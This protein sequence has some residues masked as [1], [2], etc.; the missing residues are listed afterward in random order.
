MVPD[1]RHEALD[2]TSPRGT[3]YLV[4]AQTPYTWVP[5]RTMTLT[6]RSAIEATSLSRA[7]R[8]ELRAL[9]RSVPLY[10]VQTMEHAV[11]DATAT[12]RFSTLLRKAGP[13][14]RPELLY[15]KRSDS[16]RR[17]TRC[18]SL[19]RREGEP[20]APQRP[21]TGCPEEPKCCSTLRSR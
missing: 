3:L 20:R 13:G 21:S 18:P 8:R 17:A 4:H 9:D 1:V 7:I 15:V 14:P 11:S 10:Q 6:V 5:A 2:R 12:Q 16:A 19:T